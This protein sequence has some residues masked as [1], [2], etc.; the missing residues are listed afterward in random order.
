MTKILFLILFLFPSLELI[1]QEVWEKKEEIRKLL[2]GTWESIDSETPGAILIFEGN[3]M[4]AYVRGYEDNMETFYFFL[5]T[6]PSDKFQ[7]NRID[8][9]N[10]EDKVM[11][12]GT[13]DKKTGKISLPYSFIII[14]GIRLQLRTDFTTDIDEGGVY[15]KVEE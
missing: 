10:L 1:A 9:F 5:T 7:K 13:I 11:F 15:E 8:Y 6:D 2:Q 3:I 4:Y 14:D 12:L